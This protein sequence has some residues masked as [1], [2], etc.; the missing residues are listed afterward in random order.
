MAYIGILMLLGLVAGALKVLTKT[1]FVLSFLLGA[2]IGLVGSRHSGV[3]GI[4]LF[5]GYIWVPSAAA[6]GLGWLIEK[7]TRALE[8]K[9]DRQ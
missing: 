7:G 8:R 4:F 3:F 5:A 6:W 1:F 9:F 2:F